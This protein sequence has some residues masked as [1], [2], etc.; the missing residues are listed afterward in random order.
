M[1]ISLPKPI[2]CPAA[3][4]PRAAAEGV[5]FHLGEIAKLFDRPKVTLIVRSMAM[6][7]DI[8][9]GNDD[10]EMALKAIHE[11]KREFGRAA[12]IPLDS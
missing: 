2:I 5:K 12:V 3:A 7:G 10:L 8:I 6:D 4:T 9:C 1:A 11:S